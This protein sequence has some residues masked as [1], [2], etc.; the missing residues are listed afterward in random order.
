MAAVLLAASVAA[1][2]SRLFLFLIFPVV[3]IGGWMGALGA[4][5]LLAGLFASFLSF[6]PAIPGP[7]P[8][9]GR[10]PASEA[11]SP[12]PSGRRFGGVVF[13]GPIPIVFGSDRGMTVAMLVLGIVLLVLLIA[14]VVLTFRVG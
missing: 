12:G 2:E 7:V 6:V 8:E 5:L 1:G 11:A 10:P 3:D 13:V 14:F 9:P 4:V